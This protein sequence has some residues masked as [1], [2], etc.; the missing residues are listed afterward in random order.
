ML[1]RDHALSGALAFT[2]AAPLLHVT[3]AHLAAAIA[4]TAGAGVLPDI[5][6]PG[7][8][9]AR[10]FGFLTGTFSWI[11]HRI[12]GG[13]RKGTHSLLGIALLTAA[14]L[15]AVSWQAG[16]AATSQHPELW[17]HLVPA[18]L[19]LALLF[20]AG[21]RA[22]RIGGHHGDAA[23]IALA[24]SSPRVP[25]ESGD[26]RGD[27]GRLVFL[28]EMLPRHSVQA[29]EPGGG[30]GLL[31]VHRQGHRRVLVCP[32]RLDRIG[33]VAHGGAVPG[34]LR[35]GALAA[36]HDLQERAPVVGPFDQ[37][38]VGVELGAG[39]GG[40]IADALPPH[41]VPERRPVQRPHPQ[42]PG[43]A[44]AERLH[45]PR[46]LECGDVDGGVEQGQ[47][48]DPG[49]DGREQLEPDR[50]A[51]V[52]HD[53]VEA[54]EAELLHGGQAEPPETGPAAVVATGA[55]GQAEARK[56]ESHPAQAARG[57]F[58]QHLAVQERGAD[59]AVDADDGR[60]VSFLA[61]EAGHAGGAEP[62]AGLLMR[63]EYLGAAGRPPGDRRAVAAPGGLVESGHCRSFLCGVVPLPATAR[64]PWPYRLP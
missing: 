5:D 40:G 57:Q 11:V 58:G 60:P 49:R 36:A 31:A 39:D 34:L 2:A 59:H 6:E 47:R 48:G 46:G 21:F 44:V 26:L 9:I 1:G 7:S 29:R 62:A 55:V 18:G 54:A 33:N 10:T 24:A 32:Y 25:D 28:R 35:G 17:W 56:V 4:L 43:D 37:R 64:A 23:G 3:G 45:A 14:S 61:H 16:A 19:I 20:S 52:V 38:E 50:P 41:Q 13:H 51:D 12:S 42:F 30:P 15:A 8:T 63:L 22:L 53:Q 27:G